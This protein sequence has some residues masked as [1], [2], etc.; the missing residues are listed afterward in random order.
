MADEPQP[1]AD[2][3]P[4]ADP[5]EAELVAYLDGELDPAAARK[6]ELR[7]AADPS[8]RAKAA[9]LKKTFD[10]LD[11]LPRPEPSPTFATR[12]LDK[13]PALKS[14]S[15]PVPVQSGSMP[16]RASAS[17]S[18]P[19]SNGTGAFGPPPPPSRWLKVAMIGLAVVALT[20]VGYLGAAALRPH[21]S[22]LFGP[23]DV[24]DDLPLS[25]H[26]LIEN[27]PLYA[28]VDDYEFV[29][30]LPEFFGDE[31]SVIDLPKPATPP[32]EPDKPS[33]DAFESQVKSFRAM[34]AARQQAIRELDRQLHS[35]E[36]EVRERSFR[37]LEAYAV[38]LYQLPDSERKGVFAAPTPGLRLEVVREIRERQWLNALP[39]MQRNQLTGLDSVKKA[40]KIQLWKDEEARQR[41]LW[42]FVRKNAGNKAPWPFDSEERRKPIIEFMRVTY[43][44]DEPRRVRINPID[45]AA[46]NEALA[47][48]EKGGS[49]A[50]YGKLVYELVRKVKPNGLLEY[51]VFPESADA[52]LMIQ[53]FGDLPPGL[54]KFAEAPR[55][56]RKLVP[57]VGRWPEFALELHG[58][59]PLGKFGPGPI[60]PLG[61]ARASEFK[62]PVKTFW[63]KELSRELSPQERMGLQR[64]ENRWPEYP[65]EFVRLA[66][67]HDLSVPGVT[68]PGSPQRWDATYGVG[69]SPRVPRP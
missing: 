14:G 36:T 26:R 31:Y 1:V 55:V 8:A 43:R 21:L 59:L 58:E 54:A 65:R 66:R 17:L 24:A 4:P 16:A 47:S 34:P 2:D 23:R 62:E 68:L 6:V 50:W 7:L 63:E 29:Q 57:F 49:W 28:A 48:A 56:K 18:V 44:L 13:L 64:F 11:Y 46:Y 35:V 40:E 20:G 27:L 60:A 45:L 38:W 32:V 25:D 61:P 10:L 5:F 51:E 3:G 52:K 15:L 33:R 39:A 67:K 42:V 41:N 19:L 53:D 9:A 22:H 69:P 37:V 12:T 30:K